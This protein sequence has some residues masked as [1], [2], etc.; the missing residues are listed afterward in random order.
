MQVREEVEQAEE[1]AD[2]LVALQSAPRAQQGYHQVTHTGAAVQTECS[3]F[4]TTPTPNE[5]SLKVAN[6]AL[7]LK[8]EALEH[9]DDGQD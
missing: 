6:L 2:A 8:V 5:A 4:P 7:Q 1:A 9:S 3:S